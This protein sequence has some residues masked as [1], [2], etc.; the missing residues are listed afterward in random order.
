MAC[1]QRVLESTRTDGAAA[2]IAG[3][4]AEL[5]M[6]EAVGLLARGWPE[7]YPAG[8]VE[9]LLLSSSARPGALKHFNQ[10]RSSESKFADC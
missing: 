9:W 1:A 2:G 4:A 3:S 10:S 6:R 8:A 5:W 7:D